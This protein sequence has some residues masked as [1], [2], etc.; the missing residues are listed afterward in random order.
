MR[1][2]RA[3]SSLRKAERSSSVVLTTTYSAPKV[4]VVLQYYNAALTLELAITSILN[5][6][7]E[8]WELILQDDGS[9]DGGSELAEQ[10]VC[11]KIRNIKYPINRGRA[12][13]LNE[14]IRL[15]SAP[16]I[17]VMDADDVSYPDRLS[18]QLAF[19]EKNPDVD[20]VGGAMMIFDAQGCAMGVRSGPLVHKE[21]CK[22]PGSGFPMAQPTFMGKRSWFFRY[23]YRDGASPVEDQ[24]LLMR[25]FR[26]SKFANLPDILVGYREPCLNI[27]KLISARKKFEEVIRLSPPAGS[28]RVALE[29]AVG[30]QKL[31]GLVDRVAVF[32]GLNYR[33]LRH[34]ARPPS[35]KSLSRWVDVWEKNFASLRKR[36]KVR[37]CPVPGSPGRPR[38]TVGLQVFNNESTLRFAIK[39][40]LSQTF[41]DFEL[42]I[43]DD[44]STDGT[45]DV[46]HEFRDARIRIHAESINIGRPFRLNQAIA[47]ARGSYFAIMDGDDI[48]Y[49]TR[50]E[51]QVDFLDQNPDVHLVGGQML[52]VNDLDMCLGKRIFPL[53]H[54]DICSRPWGGI[55]MAQP[56]L[57]GRVAL[58]RSV[59]Y[60]SVLRRAQDQE[61]LVR[62]CTIAKFAN[63]P[64]IVMAYREPRLSFERIV[65]GRVWYVKGVGE[66]LAARSQYLAVASLFMEQVGKGFV[67]LLAVGSGLNYAMLRHRAMPAS[68]KELADWRMIKSSLGH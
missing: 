2:Y 44:G 58:F 18:K 9:T 61:F 16:L 31:K 39:S 15:A 64:E 26:L 5:Q 46:I 33:L 21:I 35:A 37:A 42:I 4:T 12:A 65:N 10:F 47:E 29:W 17:A 25:S 27:R 8:G 34:R 50:L 11:K 56:T 20:L 63:L 43:H 45:S 23:Q 13:L 62:S 54:H 60:R 6:T 48:A 53:V 28:D 24:D 57:M 59:P 68:D 14:A 40:I 38:V 22:D 7:F 66:I 30:R 49:P 1:A 41:E 51:Q 3:A 52:I 55:P 67:D 32:S 19:L 36:D